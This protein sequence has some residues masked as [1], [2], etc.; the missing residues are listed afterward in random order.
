MS[1]LRVVDRWRAAIHSSTSLS[2]SRTVSR[3]LLSTEELLTR[4]A[5]ALQPGRGVRWGRMQPQ[6]C[7]D[8]NRSGPTQKYTTLELK[9]SV[10]SIMIKF[11]ITR[12][13]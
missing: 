12:V 6:E 1:R 4:S 10:I 3:R 7:K 9:H 5:M 13:L 11:L 8:Q 2:L